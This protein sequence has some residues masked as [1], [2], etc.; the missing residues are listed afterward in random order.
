MTLQMCKNTFNL[1]LKKKKKKVGL[2]NNKL[3]ERKKKMNA[4]DWFSLHLVSQISGKR[5]IYQITIEYLL[6]P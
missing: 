6:H 1:D 4:F 5:G 2:Q 3:K